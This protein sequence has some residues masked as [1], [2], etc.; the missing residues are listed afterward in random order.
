[1]KKLLILFTAI[2]LAACSKDNGTNEPE[3]DYTSF[4]FYTLEDLTFPNCVAGYFDD[5]GYCWKL[6]DLGE[7]TKDKMSSEI[8]IEDVDITYVYL[9][10]DYFGSVMFDYAFKVKSNIKNVFQIIPGTKGIEADKTN[11]KEYP[12]E[13]SAD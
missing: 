10:T 5:E 9:F 8:I 2:A 6:G 11:P 7:L 1:M 4:M 13:K 3:Q 12:Q